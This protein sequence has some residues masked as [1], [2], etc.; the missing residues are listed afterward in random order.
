MDKW[1][2]DDRLYFYSRCHAIVDAT[3]FL[4]HKAVRVTVVVIIA[5]LMPVIPFLVVGELPGERWLSSTDDNTLIFALTGSGLLAVD[6]ALPIPSSLVGTALGARLGFWFGFI[7]CWVGM[8]A[9]NIAG[10]YF[11][12][13]S[14]QRFATALPR[15]PTVAILFLSRPVPV[16]AEAAALAAGAIRLPLRPFMASCALGN[17]VYASAL[18]ANAAFWLPGDW[19]GPGLVLPMLLP[20]VLWFAWRRLGSPAS[21]HR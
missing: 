16:A 21:V 2:S 20:V 17:A 6:L 4:V 9:G 13:L 1:R 11:G 8:M 3:E 7:S 18:C 15:E 5:V 12:R 19:K 14:P 10:Y